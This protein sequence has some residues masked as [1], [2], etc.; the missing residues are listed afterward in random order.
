MAEPSD[1]TPNT[2]KP[3]EFSSGVEENDPVP[4]LQSGEGLPYAP[5]DWPN[6]GDTWGWRVGRRFNSLGYYIDRY[7]YLPSSLQKPTITKQFA[8]KLAVERYIQSEFPDA[9]LDAFWAS[10]SWKVPALKDSAGATPLSAVYATPLSAVYAASSSAEKVEEGKEENPV[11][12]N[13]KR[14]HTAVKSL[15][16]GRTRRSVRQATKGSSRVNGNKRV[17]SNARRKNKKGTADFEDNQPDN[18]LSAGSDS[19]SARIQEDFKN[20]LDSLIENLAQPATGNSPAQENELAQNQIP[21]NDAN[22]TFLHEDKEKIIQQ[23]QADINTVLSAIQGID[24]QIGQL[25]SRQAEVMKTIETKKGL[26]A[27]LSVDRQ[28]VGNGK[29]TNQYE[30]NSEKPDES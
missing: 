19:P 16:N 28:K 3:E 17:T 24:N 12:T 1:F 30:L 20:Y 21:H 18:G 29:M 14:K 6:P 2:D 8:S 5:I 10:F 7:L 13:R 15:A 23:L 22:A 11:A 26:I 4:A 27:K 25:Q 9:D